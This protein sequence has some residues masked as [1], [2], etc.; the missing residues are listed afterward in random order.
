MDWNGKKMNELERS[1]ISDAF[2]KLD[3]NLAATARALG[4]SRPK[5]YRKLKDYGLYPRPKIKSKA[6]VVTSGI[7]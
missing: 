7:E 2:H 1:V 5:L 3:Y 4:I 6:K